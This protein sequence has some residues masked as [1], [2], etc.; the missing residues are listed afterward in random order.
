MDPMRRILIT[1]NPKILTA[2]FAVHVVIE[3]SQLSVLEANPHETSPSWNCRSHDL[4]HDAKPPFFVVPVRDFI[5]H[6][7][8]ESFPFFHGFD[9]SARP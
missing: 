1:L 2:P 4:H 8:K 7:E 5:A 9:L 6:A 3:D